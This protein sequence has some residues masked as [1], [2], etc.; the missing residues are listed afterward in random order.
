M[1]RGLIG[2]ITEKEFINVLSTSMDQSHC[3]TTVTIGDNFSEGYK[4]HRDTCFTGNFKHRNNYS[5]GGIK[6][7]KRIR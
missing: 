2:S 6:K 5:G 3:T 7:K 1:K 4:R